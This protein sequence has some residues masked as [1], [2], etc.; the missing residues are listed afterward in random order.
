MKY[1]NLIGHAHGPYSVVPRMVDSI[2]SS[3]GTVDSIVSQG[4]GGN[5]LLRLA[6]DRYMFYAWQ[7]PAKG[8]WSRLTTL[9]MTPALPIG[10]PTVLLN[11]GRAANTR[12]QS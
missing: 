4:Y 8:S 7:P 2:V 1:C 5:A 3:D 11:V 10:R 9:A 12:Y 6:T